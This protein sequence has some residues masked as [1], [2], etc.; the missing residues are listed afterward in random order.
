V[1]RLCRTRNGIAA[2]AALVAAGLAASAS[3]QTPEA[4]VMYHAL[5]IVST[6]E[7][8]EGC[9]LSLH[10]TPRLDETTGHWLVAYSGVGA[11]CDDR[12]EALQ[13]A[14]VPAEITFYR[15]P[16]ADEIVALI[17][18]MRAA[19]RRGYPCQ[20]SFRGNP[21]FNAEADIWAVGYYASGQECQGA[22][23]ALE[24]RGRAFG[25]GF[26]RTR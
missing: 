17:G 22:T 19:V 15:R 7:Q 6:L 21:H 25:V 24:R 18:S 12:G 23:E 9:D 26:Y 4:D 20:I 13:R 2:G 1:R 10:G 8:T 14:G 16:N 11:A 5:Q 3:A